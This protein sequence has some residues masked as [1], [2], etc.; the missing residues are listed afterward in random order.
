[1]RSDIDSLLR[2]SSRARDTGVWDPHDLSFCEVTFEQIFGGV[3]DTHKTLVK[4][5]SQKEEK[6]EKEEE[7]DDRRSS[8]V[9]DSR[10]SLR[11]EMEELK[12][13]SEERRRGS[14]S[15]ENGRGRDVG[16][17]SDAAQAK[18]RDLRKQVLRQ[19][20]RASEYVREGVEK[21]K[22]IA[23]LESQITELNSEMDELKE[24]NNANLTVINRLKDS[25]Q[26][27]TTRLVYLDSDEPGAGRSPSPPCLSSTASLPSLPSGPT[28]PNLITYSSKFARSLSRRSSRSSLATRLQEQLETSQGEVQRLEQRAS[29]LATQVELSSNARL[30]AESALLTTRRE[31]K[32]LAVEHEN[33]KD[34][35]RALV[36][37]REEKKLRRSASTAGEE[38]S[39]ATDRR[40]Q[41]GLESRLG[42][43]IQ[44]LR[45]REEEME[46]VANCLIK[47]EQ[48]MEGVANC[49]DSVTIQLC[50]REAEIAGLRGRVGALEEQLSHQQ[51]ALRQGGDR[52][53]TRSFPLPVRVIYKGE[54][55]VSGEEEDRSEGLSSSD[56]F[57][58]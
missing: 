43:A 20:T 33:L 6:K 29:D 4:K 45:Q 31:L 16:D 21:N 12:R 36:R 39:S 7:D 13:R 19:Q 3:E 48:E 23:D 17:R 38:S 46:G 57:N 22:V 25:L 50:E 51:Q 9:Y 26:E 41:E 42:S 53:R 30:Q 56:S 44:Q 37:R 54:S 35:F 47:R 52:Q 5:A 28:G 2:L 15:E 34:D 32:E 18:I 40:R 58:I 55:E 11:S 27:T 49:L 10:S 14:Q 8:N 1:L 24:E